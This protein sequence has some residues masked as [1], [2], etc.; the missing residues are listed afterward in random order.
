MGIS[1]K[2]TA[3]SKDGC[4]KRTWV[5]QFSSLIYFYK[6][7]LRYLFCK[8]LH[9]LHMKCN[10]QGRAISGKSC[11]DFTGIHY[12]YQTLHISCKTLLQKEIRNSLK[13]CL[14]ECDSQGFC[15]S[16]CCLNVFPLSLWLPVRLF[17]LLLIFSWSNLRPWNHEFCLFSPKAAHAVTLQGLFEVWYSKKWKRSMVTL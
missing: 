14:T 3:L 10:R 12:S 9:C 7:S 15:I 13:A 4:A 5:Q 8:A 1:V 17:F 6:Y 16:L 11:Q 2:P